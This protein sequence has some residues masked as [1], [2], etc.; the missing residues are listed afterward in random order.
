MKPLWAHQ[1]K[2][3]ARAEKAASLAAFMEP[4]TGKTRAII[5]VLRRD[6]ARRKGIARTLIICPLST[7]K[8][9]QV[10]FS[11]YSL[12]NP[13]C[14]KALTG[15]GSVRIEAL[16]GAGIAIT[17]FEGVQIKAFYEA[18][19]HWSPEIVIIDESHRIKDSA[20]VRAKK[21]YPLAHAARRRFI[22]TGTP[23]L[24]TLLDLFGQFKA[25]D[26]LI[27]GG[28]FWEFR[29][30]YFYDKNAGMPKHLHFPDWR[31]IRGVEKMLGEVIERH[32]V[33]AKK[34]ECLDLPELVSVEIPIELGQD[35]ARIYQQMENEFVAEL[36]DVTATAEFAMT[37]SLRLQ[38]IIA[39][40]VSEGAGTESAWVSD[41]PRLT[42][43]KETLESL[44]KSQVI[45]WT[46]FVP[47]YAVIAGVLKALKLTFTSLT[48][49][50]SI[51]EKEQA[52]ASFKSGESQVLISNP[53]AGGT[54]VDGLQVAPYAI[55]Y[56]RSFNLEHFIQSRDRNHRGGSEVHDK[57]A[58]FHLIAKGTVD[59]VVFGALKAKKRIGDA[60]QEW[61]RGKKLDTSQSQV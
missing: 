38:Q 58:H 29:K 44:G 55:Y 57:I 7:V 51:S 45:L 52:I 54:G 56:T 59:E 28:S 41:N 40:F 43:L 34:S 47:S 30:R 42:A 12:I 46:N 48:G 17:N 15:A 53:S 36:G 22:L 8:Q 31:P 2:F 19:L 27:F 13:K 39:G 26:P 61:S 37:K 14:I 60:L 23:V 11:E 32:V 6:F 16:Q 4:G 9:W 1:E 10:A 5:E 25:L 50:Q 18:L 21:I 3:V 49:Q 20:S 24:N 33:S 35:Q